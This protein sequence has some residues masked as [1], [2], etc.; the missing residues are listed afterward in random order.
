MKTTAVVVLA[1]SLAG[2]VTD[3]RSRRI[4]NILTVGGALAALLF[5]TMTGGITGAG[6]AAAG[7]LAGAAVFFLPFYLGGMG[8]GDVKL[9]AALGAWLGPPLTIWLAIYTGIAGAVLAMAVALSAGYL[10]QAL[11]NVWLL[12][13]HW[14]A[15]GLRPLDEVTLAHS[16]A[17]RLAYAVPICAGTVLTLWLR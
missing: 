15:S 10:R 5:H 2:C 16:A 9:M 12:L 7:W 4:P 6:T 17:P 8:A 14:R 1:I 13:A 11:S 3:L